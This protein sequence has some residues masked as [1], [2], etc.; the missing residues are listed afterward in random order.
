[1]KAKWDCV[2]T[3]GRR[4]TTWKMRTG[5]NNPPPLLKTYLNVWCFH[6]QKRTTKR[7]V[8][9]SRSVTKII[10]KFTH[11]IPSKSFFF[12]QFLKKWL[13]DFFRNIFKGGERKRKKLLPDPCPHKRQS[14]SIN[15]TLEKEVVSG[16]M[17]LCGNHRVSER[18]VFFFLAF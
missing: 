14:I 11:P 12:Y 18:L 4:I 3:W 17:Q 2:G 1:M 15:I 9:R 7:N 5:S 6:S 8:S 10:Q 13:I 16:G